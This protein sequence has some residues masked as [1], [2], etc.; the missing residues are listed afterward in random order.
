MVFISCNH[1]H[2]KNEIE[3]AMQKYDSL[4]QAMDADGISKMFTPDGKLGDAAQ[5]RDSIKKLLSSFVN[6][7]VLSQSSNTKSIELKN[8]SATQT[9]MYFQTAVIEGKDTLHLKG[10]YTINW[11]LLDDEGWKIKK[12]VTE[13]MQ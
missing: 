9:G 3:S 10:K 13:P 4:I 2:S 5:G 7:K 11:R 8:D 6:S 12:I 1:S